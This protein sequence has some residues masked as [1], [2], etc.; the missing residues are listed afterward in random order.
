MS[1]KKVDKKKI[2]NSPKSLQAYHLLRVIGKSRYGKLY[3][4]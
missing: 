3:L 1:I 4:A 2:E